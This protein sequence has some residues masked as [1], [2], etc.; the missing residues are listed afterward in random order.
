MTETAPKKS[1][2]RVLKDF[3]I[4]RVQA[5]IDETFVDVVKQF[6]E[7]VGGDWP[8][9][10]ELKMGEIRDQIADMMLDWA[11]K[12][13]GPKKGS[14]E[15]L[16]IERNK[17]LRDYCEG[18]ITDDGFEFRHLGIKHWVI[19]PY[20]DMDGNPCFPEDYYGEAYRKWRDAEFTDSNRLLSELRKYEIARDKKNEKRA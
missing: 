3:I 7:I 11:L 8:P 12:N 20:E 14:L 2:E 4:E 13:L 18:R 16:R 9:D 17:W 10:Q 19:D 15:E 5:H 1:K 6:P